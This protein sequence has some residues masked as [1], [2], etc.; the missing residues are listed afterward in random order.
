MVFSVLEKVDTY[1]EAKIEQI[2][3][4]MTLF[5]R[6]TMIRSLGLQNQALV[7]AHSSLKNRRGKLIKKGTAQLFKIKNMQKI[8]TG[9]RWRVIILLAWGT[10]NTT[11]IVF[12]I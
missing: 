10:R 4:S 7:R 11:F 3:S 6:E 5:E 12:I 9:R 2:F 8:T 1:T